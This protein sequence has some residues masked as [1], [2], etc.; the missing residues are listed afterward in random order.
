MD[1]PF[2]SLSNWKDSEA[3]AC[4][5]KIFHSFAWYELH[6]LQMYSLSCHSSALCHAPLPVNVSQFRRE[7]G[8]VVI[9]SVQCM[10]SVCGICTLRPFSLLTILNGRV[11]I[12][13]QTH[14]YNNTNI[15][16]QTDVAYYHCLICCQTISVIIPGSM[17]LSF[18]YVP[19]WAFHYGFFLLTILQEWSETYGGSSLLETLYK[20]LDEVSFTSRSWMKVVPRDSFLI[21]SVAGC[22][23]TWMWNLQLQSR[24]WFRPIPWERSN[25]SFCITDVHC[26]IFFVKLLYNLSCFLQMVFQFL[27]LQQKTKA[28]CQFPVFLLKVGENVF[29]SLDISVFVETAMST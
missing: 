23:V 9:L 17:V 8:W 7:L 25:V 26:M 15:I 20:A 10:I 28:C 13:P 6:L 14:L 24:F 1:T 4:G 18:W 27:L 19:L 3:E 16:V 12:Q 5:K 2:F 29:I 22:E 11:M 21:H